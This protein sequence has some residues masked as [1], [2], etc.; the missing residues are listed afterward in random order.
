MASMFPVSA[1]WVTEMSGALAV[2]GS[3]ALTIGGSCFVTSAIGLASSTSG[4][5]TD[6]IG[7]A[8]AI[9]STILGRLTFFNS[10]NSFFNFSIP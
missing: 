9:A 10:S 5:G 7:R 8:S 3:G 2:D 4:G 1:A 6:C